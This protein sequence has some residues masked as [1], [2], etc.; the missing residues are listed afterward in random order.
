M[1]LGIRDN[2]IEE[3]LDAPVAAERLLARN[4]RDIRRINRL[5]GWTSLAVQRVSEL[6][7]RHKLMRFTLLDVAT[8]SADI[9]L[10]LARWAARQGLQISITATDLSEQVLA[11]ARANCSGVENI[12]IERQDGLALTYSAQSYDLALCSLALHHFSPHDAPRLLVEL[13]RVAR[14]A[15]IVND[16]ARSLPAYLG[17]WLLTHTLM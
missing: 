6:V 13:A 11:N 9:P 8:G 15:V 4:L 7:V 10:A 3:L 14:C 12:Q 2:S 5:L 17:A 1:N 16:L